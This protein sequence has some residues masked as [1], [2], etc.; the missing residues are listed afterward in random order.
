MLNG[1]LSFALTTAKIYSQP[2]IDTLKYI[3]Y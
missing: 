3:T 2:F 1:D